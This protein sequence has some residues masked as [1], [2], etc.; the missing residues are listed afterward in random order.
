MW[1]P[2]QH[3]VTATVLVLDEQVRPV[4]GEV[5]EATRIG[6]KVDGLRVSDT[7]AVDGCAAFT[8]DKARRGTYYCSISDI[9]R[10]GYVCCLYCC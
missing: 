8:I 9:F 7:T 3:T 10:D 6:P 5:V 1:S 4:E 2:G